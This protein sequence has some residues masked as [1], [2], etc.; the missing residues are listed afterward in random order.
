MPTINGSSGNDI[1][2]DTSGDD[3]LNGLGGHDSLIVTNGDDEANGGEGLD[4]LA[5]EWSDAPEVRTTVAPT[6][7]P[8]GFSGSYSSGTAGRRVD[9]SGIERFVINSGAGNDEI[10]TA[11]GNDVISTGAGS[12]TIQSGSGNDL[13]NGGA[14]ADSMSGGA[15]DDIYFVH[16]LGDTITELADEGRDVVY[17]VASYALAAGVHLEVLSTATIGATGAIDLTGNERPN[18]I[19][20]NNGANV[21]RGEAGNDTLIGF[22]GNDTL[23][24][25][26]EDDVLNGG[27]GTDTMD[28]GDGNDIY[29]VH[30]PSD[31]IVEA[32]A[33]TL[34]R[35][36]VYSVDSYTLT[37]GARV[38]VLSVAS[39][40]G[41]T[42]INLTGNEFDNEIYGNSGFNTLRG[43]GGNDALFG[44]GERD[45]L[46]GGAGDDRLDGGPGADRME[47]GEGADIYFVGSSD[48]VVVE[49]DSSPERDVV[50]ASA[51]FALPTGIEVLSAASLVDTTPLELTGNA[52]SNE[53]LGNAG[54]NILRGSAVA[55]GGGGNDVLIGLAGDDILIG[56][57]G[58]DIL[59]GG[60]GVDRMDGYAG[61]DIYFVDNPHDLI[62]REDN[63]W[64][65]IDVVYTS[66]DYTLPEKDLEVLS[67]SDLSA[68]TPLRLTGNSDDNEILGNAG[69]NILAGGGGFDELVGGG[70]ADIFLFESGF[71]GGSADLIYDFEI[72][73]DKIAVKGGMTPGALPPGAFA[74]S[75]S[76]T[77]TDN[78]DRVLY[79]P[80][81]GRVWFDP[82]GTG[83]GGFQLIAFVQPGLALSAD[84]FMVV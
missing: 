9:Y 23:F 13:I 75:S 45:T 52:S 8:N 2:V 50:Y 79:D 40:A 83:P 48:D 78:D 25:G 43:E 22:A 16:D 15:G 51:S 41:T 57:G 6:A 31:V 3:V 81:T 44:R 69:A 17:A 38:E 67:A 58:D 80:A 68:T 66:V 47:G 19:L 30:D 59:N 12:D 28:G 65:G 63:F 56:G 61:S 1:I 49:P 54:D 39:L 24:G 32:N 74:I 53:I 35:D 34:E 76:G 82:D 77:A 37:P 27:A 14:G 84:D 4:S 62:D 42:S 55:G 10:V 36:V 5:L 7:D 73:I 60:P 18:E 70:G 46:I 64:P 26:S 33:S 21:L 11:S 71:G 72:G 29:F 20:G